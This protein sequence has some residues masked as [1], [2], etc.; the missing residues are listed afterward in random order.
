MRKESK[1]EAKFISEFA[2]KHKIPCRIETIP[3]KKYSRENKISLETAGR[4]LRYE[5]FG[6]LAKA[7]RCNLIATGHNANDNAET[8]L[9]WLVRGTGSEGVSGIP[10]I[11]NVEHSKTKI[12]RPI[13]CLSR[14][15]IMQY[16]KNQK[17]K[18]CI[19]KSNFSSDF[20]RNRFRHEVVPVLEKHNPCFVEHL[21]NWSQISAMESD[22]ISSLVQKA[23]KLV[24]STKN[25]EI[26]LDLKRFFGYNKVL[27]MRLIK[28][29]L[30]EKRSLIHI[31]RV[32]EWI[33]DGRSSCL[34]FSSNWTLLKTSKKVFFRKCR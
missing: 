10:L 31:E 21:Y 22:F 9:M 24:V 29:I 1:H 20:T 17:L 15:E 33:L 2:E 14:T 6:K 30:P 11:R 26:S 3:V 27:Q 19:D 5:T 34:E 13:L 32:F 16:I 25:R 8:V 18:Y 12:I 23:K 4:I 28:S 7:N